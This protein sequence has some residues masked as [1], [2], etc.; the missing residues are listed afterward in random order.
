MHDHVLCH[1]QHRVSRRLTNPTD[2]FMCH[3][4]IGHCPADA[5]AESAK[6]D[7]DWCSSYEDSGRWIMDSFDQSLIGGVKEMCR[8]RTGERMRRVAMAET[9]ASSM[10]DLPSS[11]KR[12]KAGEE[13]RSA[14]RSMM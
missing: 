3:V 14:T 11:T 5:W 9:A 2:S 8:R 1:G 6:L 4:S 10:H 13:R 7:L 12:V